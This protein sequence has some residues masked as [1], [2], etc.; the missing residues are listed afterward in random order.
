MWI[1][2][3]LAHGSIFWHLHTQGDLGY[4]DLHLYHWWVRSADVPVFDV[5]WV[6]PLLALIPMSILSPIADSAHYL[7]AWLGLATV[8][9]A[10]VVLLMQRRLPNGSL[11]AGW[12]C[13]FIGALGPVAL[14]RLDTFASALAI[15]AVIAILA[16]PA[17]TAMA[18]TFLAIA[19]WVKVAHGF[20]LLP[21]LAVSA[22]PARAVLAP[23]AGVSALVLLI[24]LG[25]GGGSRVL[26]FLSTQSDRGL[27]VESV[28]A[29]P[30]H[31]ARSLGHGYLPVYNDDI[32]TVEYPQALAAQIAGL[33][34]YALG[35]AVLIVTALAFGA[36]RRR[37]GDVRRIVVAALLAVTVCLLIFNKVGSPQLMLW[38]VAPIIGFLALAGK[39]VSRVAGWLIAV[40]GLAIAGLTQAIFPGGYQGFLD[41]D[42]LYLG[43]YYVRCAL[44]VSLLLAALVVLMRGKRNVSDVID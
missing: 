30:F 34:D 28:L 27:Q 39:E 23:A 9:N 37:P 17:K 31:V 1:L 19:A 5:D 15:V 43:F 7:W 14:A 38:L 6:Y 10:A 44:L 4:G 25:G 24:A 40:M 20:W 41:A 35:L 13:V 32:N 12:W 36:S 18:S 16:Q 21:L 8:V 33:A 2:F 29:A 22:R 42:P 26:S 3:V 11:A